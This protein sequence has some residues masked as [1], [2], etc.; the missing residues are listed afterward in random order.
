MAASTST[1]L[2]DLFVNIIAQARFTAEEQSLLMGLVT[3]TISA[4][5]LVKRFRFL[6]TLQFLPLTLL[7]VLI[8]QARLLAPAR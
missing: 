4:L 7:K 2:D 5:T 8:C 3:V 6:N 1:T